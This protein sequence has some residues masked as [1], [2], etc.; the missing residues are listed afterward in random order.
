MRISCLHR[1]FIHLLTV[2]KPPPWPISQTKLSNRS[3]PTVMS[4]H[5]IPH[6]TIPY[7]IC[8]NTQPRTKP[9]TQNRPPLRFPRNSLYACR[10][11]TVQH[12]TRH[13]TTT[14]ELLLLVGD[15]GEKERKRGSWGLPGLVSWIDL[16]LVVDG[17]VYILVYAATRE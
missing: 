16:E 5:V 12:A 9:T 14:A 10:K 1:N 15:R 4:C 7:H 8:H 17:R 3:N 11:H 2:D 6:S 13:D